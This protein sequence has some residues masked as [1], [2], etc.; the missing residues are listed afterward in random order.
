[1]IFKNKTRK[2]PSK[3]FI[4]PKYSNMSVRHCNSIYTKNIIMFKTKVVKGSPS[5]NH[6]KSEVVGHFDTKN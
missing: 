6:Y 1:M 2:Y 4:N 5:I 3:R